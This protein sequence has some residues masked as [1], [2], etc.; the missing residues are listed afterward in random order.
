MQQVSQR[1]AKRQDAQQ[2]D[3][4]QTVERLKGK[5]AGV[6]DELDRHFAQQHLQMS[7]VTA[8]IEGRAEP[9][10]MMSE[11]A[12]LAVSDSAPLTQPRAAFSDEDWLTLARCSVCGTAD[13]TVV[14]EWNKLILLDTAPDERSRRYD[15]ALCHGCGLL[16]ATERPVGARY[17]YLM[18]H[19]T[20]NRCSRR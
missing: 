17:Q 19:F 2:R 14:C 3:L 13:R 1:L 4:L 18:A 11:R 8:L 20:H 15:Y 16:Y 6:R 10:T 12:P 9:P 7:R 5:I